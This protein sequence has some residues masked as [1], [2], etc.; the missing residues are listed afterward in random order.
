MPDGR[1]PYD[2]QLAVEGPGE[3]FV[4]PRRDYHLIE[5]PIAPRPQSRNRHEQQYRQGRQE[6]EQAAGH[7]CL[8]SGTSQTPVN[9]SDANPA[10]TRL[11]SGLKAWAG[12]S[13]SL[14]GMDSTSESGRL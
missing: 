8:G 7:G 14:W 6:V 11:P 12:T 10:A 3:G 9:P 13:P 1:Q 2:P 4:A 5:P